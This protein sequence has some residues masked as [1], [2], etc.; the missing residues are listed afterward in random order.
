M[1]YSSSHLAAK[2]FYKGLAVVIFLALLILF[3][4]LAKP[5][6][7]GENH[8]EEA[9]NIPEVQY[10][11][12]ATSSAGSKSSGDDESAP[13]C[14]NISSH[15]DPCKFVRSSCSEINALIPYLEFRYCDMVKPGLPG[16]AYLI[17]FLS[18]LI[19]ISLLATTAEYFFVPSL[20][21]LS[22]KLN[23]SPAIAGITLLALGNGAPDIFT[24][25]AGLQADDFPLV[26][27]GL[28]GASMF[29]ATVV[30][31]SVMLAA[32][33]NS[34]RVDKTSLMRDVSV[35]LVATVV[36]IAVSA[37]RSIALWEALLFLILYILYVLIVV[38]HSRIR[39]AKAQGRS[40]RVGLF[41]ADE[42]EEHEESNG[43]SS[44]G[45]ALAPITEFVAHDSIEN[46]GGESHSAS[47]LASG[48]LNSPNTIDSSIRSML[49]ELISAEELEE[50]N[51]PN[52]L[53][54]LSWP[55]EPS[56]VTRI[57]YFIEFPWSFLRWLTSPP[58]DGKWNSKRRLLW[59]MH[60]FVFALVLLVASQGWE[61]FSMK[62]GNSDMPLPVLL[63][64]LAG[65]V[66][67]SIYCLSN[68]Q[69]LPIFY[70]A[71]SLISFVAAIA[72]LNIIASECVS[73]L[74]TFGL[75]LNISTSLLGL[76]VLAVGNS[77]G[78][79]V[80]DV[81]VARAGSPATSI[82]ACFG[83]PLLNDMGGLGISLTITTAKMYP[84]L[85]EFGLTKQLYVGW[86]F[87]CT[88]LLA[89]AI[90][91]PLSRYKPPKS[92]AWYE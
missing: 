8:Q 89:S 19:C 22:D 36:I 63:E 13:S 62:V 4:S 6:F 55:A 69:R 74:Q 64:L 75:M 88:A 23:L 11:L 38:I 2:G 7:G 90:M 60:P 82:A 87:L 52:F 32:P 50:E 53:M 31:G 15:A 85:F 21:Y 26:L 42:M 44:N 29:I 24:A 39:K 14:E 71:F 47:L 48:D 56:L 25:I 30:L 72:W 20:Q 80:A 45:V 58:A 92:F 86:S 73:I 66:A 1:K 57:Q 83:S 67:L 35:Y 79:W 10:S 12:F 3:L 70:P 17:L 76:T 5:Y 46:R 43:N 84:K 41:G 18:L 40:Y 81:A 16:L 27:G 33:R 34:V 37:T 54:G 77:V 91:F 78:D 68:A 28:V 65:V 51:N 49:H 61:G 59:I 9:V